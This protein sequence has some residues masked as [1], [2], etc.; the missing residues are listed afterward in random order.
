MASEE[1]KKKLNENLKYLQSKEKGKIQNCQKTNHL[2]RLTRKSRPIRPTKG[3]I[4]STRKR[5]KR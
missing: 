2:Y 5:A 4:S 3:K 1:D